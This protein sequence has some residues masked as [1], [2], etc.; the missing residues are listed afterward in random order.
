MKFVISY[1]LVLLWLAYLI[2]SGVYLFSRG[3]LLSRVSKTDVSSC[4]HLSLDPND[5][6]IHWYF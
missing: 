3:F 1:S 6:S 5:V 4:R 2:A